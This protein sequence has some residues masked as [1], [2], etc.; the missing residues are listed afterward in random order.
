[1]AVLTHIVRM[2]DNEGMTQR[3]KVRDQQA[4][5]AGPLNAD[6]QSLRYTSGKSTQVLDIGFLNVSKL[7]LG[8]VIYCAI[9]NV[10]NSLEPAVN[11]HLTKYMLDSI[12]SAA[13]NPQLVDNVCY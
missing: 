2:A 7:C 8:L 1:M 3:V 12:V 10:L 9:L 11:A 13:V 6:V 5:K 4:P